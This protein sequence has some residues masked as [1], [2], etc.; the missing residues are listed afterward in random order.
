MN[1]ILNTFIIYHVILE[2]FSVSRKKGIINI[3]ILSVIGI[4]KKE[5]HLK[6]QRYERILIYYVYYENIQRCQN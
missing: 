5:I 6:V 4:L 1:L 3:Q 2:L